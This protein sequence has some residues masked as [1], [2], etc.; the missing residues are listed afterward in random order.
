MELMIRQICKYC[1]SLAMGKKVVQLLS[2]QMLCLYFGSL[3]Y[4]LF[5]KLLKRA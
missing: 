4:P 3:V 5:I 1:V 2:H